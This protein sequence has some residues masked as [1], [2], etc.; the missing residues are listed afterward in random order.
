MKK[1]WKVGIALLVVLL[2]GLSSSRIL[3]RRHFFEHAN[4]DRHYEKILNRFNSKLHLSPDQ[5]TKV[6]ATLDQS[7]QR[8]KALR[9]E[10][11]PKFDEIRDSANAE[12]RSVL[13]PDQQMKFDEMQ[14][15]WKARKGKRQ[16]E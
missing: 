6:A 1:F 16:S 15:E 14:A 13:N 12:I 3:F 10:L 2:L 11:R 4:P 8:I 7:R 5:K 9:A